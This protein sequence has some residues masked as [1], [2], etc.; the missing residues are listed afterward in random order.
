[1][2]P[3]PNPQSPIPNPHP[4]K[5]KVYTFKIQKII[6]FIKNNYLIFKNGIKRC[7]R[8]I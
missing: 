6:S 2:G 7:F 8:R 5:K 4:N 1:L 3:I